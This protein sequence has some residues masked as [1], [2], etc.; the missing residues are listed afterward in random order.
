VEALLAA[1]EASPPAAAL[2]ASFYAYPLVNAAHVLGA[3]GLVATVIL[4]DLQLLGAF[5]SVEREPYARLMRR[6]ALNL[7]ALAIV[8]GLLLFS[9]QARD[10]AANPAFLAKVALLVAA[11]ANFLMLAPAA[12]AGATTTRARAGA[13]LS[14]AVWPAVLIAGRFIGF[15]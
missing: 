12:G 5:G 9:V 7:F 10:Y 15:V 14:L 2:R 4:L 6:A 3:G 1:I 13:I 11:I 8:T